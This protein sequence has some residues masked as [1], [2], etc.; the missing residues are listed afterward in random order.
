[1]LLVLSTSSHADNCKNNFL[2]FVE[3]PADDNNGSVVQQRKSLVLT[4]IKQS[5]KFAWV[6]IAMVII[7]ICLLME[8]KSISL[9]QITKMSIFATQFCLGT[10]S[11]NFV[12]TESR[13]VSFKGN[14]YDFSV[15]YS[16]IDKSVILYIHMYLMVKSE[17]KHKY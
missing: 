8:K 10:I 5:Q 3:G 16:A 1:M 11:E 13:E 9:K 7:V 14:V 2:A 12:A 15:D 6:C 17:T 4:L